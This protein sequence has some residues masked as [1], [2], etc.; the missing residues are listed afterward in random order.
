M[1][2]SGSVH[3]F[4]ISLIQ[5]SFLVKTLSQ[6]VE[7]VLSMTLCV[8]SGLLTKYS[9]FSRSLLLKY[10]YA[11]NGKPKIVLSIGRVLCVLRAHVCETDFSL[12]KLNDL[13]FLDSFFC[14][15]NVN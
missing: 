5:P 1:L 13:K 15:G 3:R 10:C 4:L 6:I 12:E 8:S 2:S 14:F 9:T 11:A 7:N